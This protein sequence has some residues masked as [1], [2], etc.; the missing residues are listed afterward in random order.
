M[1]LTFTGSPWTRR[2]RKGGLHPPVPSQSTRD[3][4]GR[5]ACANAPTHLVL[6]ADPRRYRE[7][8]EWQHPGILIRTRGCTAIAK[9]DAL[10][11]WLPLFDT[12][13]PLRVRAAASLRATIG[14][15]DA[16]ARVLLFA[17][18]RLSGV[19]RRITGTVAP[20]ASQLCSSD[21]TARPLARA[22][23]VSIPD[24]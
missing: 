12:L 6:S 16:Q 11:V 5:C 7:Q 24:P 20:G 15:Q 10:V 14:R 3:S 23:E 9:T 8:N 18:Q 17:D 2:A 19:S 21:T 4:I 13:V 22:I 1:R